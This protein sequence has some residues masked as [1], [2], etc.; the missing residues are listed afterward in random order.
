MSGHV[1]TYAPP[2]V[3]RGVY[4]LEDPDVYYVTAVRQGIWQHF[5][6]PDGRV[7]ARN[8]RRPVGR[9]R[10]LPYPAPSRWQARRWSVADNGQYGRPEDAGEG[11]R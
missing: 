8:G 1:V 10:K 3:L 5:R 6:G 7:E 11:N 9:L 4:S 2:D